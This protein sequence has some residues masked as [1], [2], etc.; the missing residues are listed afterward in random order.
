M[1]RL[2]NSEKSNVANAIEE[3][4][5][6]NPKDDRECFLYINEVIELVNQ[7]ENNAKYIINEEG[8]ITY[9]L[10]NLLKGSEYTTNQTE[11]VNKFLELLSNNSEKTEYLVE[12]VFSSLGKSQKEIQNAKMDFDQL[13]TQVRMIAQVFDEFI[14][15]I[16]NIQTKYNSIQGFANIIT[17][18]AQQTNLLSLNASIEAARAGE[19]GKGFSV[20]ANEIKKLSV[21][22]QKNAKDIIDSLKNLT[23]SMEQLSNKSTQGTTVI[24]KTTN[25]IEKSSS[26]LEK[27]I[28]SESEVSE[29]IKEVKESQEENL[30]GIKEISVNLGQ[31]VEKSKVENKQLQDI[32][33]SIQKKA[34]YYV[35]VFNYLNQIETLKEE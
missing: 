6:M 19:A 27:I 10:D 18:I 32:L 7:I 2:L 25:I 1:F 8:S 11:K 13:I 26:I 5:Q 4:T 24:S 31:L 21:D 23:T 14:K 16:D 20:V 29:N 17:G 34:D 12:N 22:T 33:G 30:H 35:N 15:L 9:G 3:K 28:E